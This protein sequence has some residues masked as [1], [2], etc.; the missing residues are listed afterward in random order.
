MPYIYP[1]TVETRSIQ[2][3]YISRDREQRL[4]LKLMPIV[5]KNVGKI[6]WS[7]KDTYGGLQNLRGLDGRPTRV[8]RV[9]WTTYE[10]EPGVFGEF[11]VVT[12]TELTNRAQN[13][14]VLTTPIDVGDLVLEQDELLVQRENDRI[15]SSIWTLLTTGTLQILLDG[16]NGTQYGVNDAYTFQQYTPLVGWSNAGSSTPLVDFQNIQQKGYA[17]GRSVNFGAG[18]VAYCNQVTLNRLLNNQN[19]ADLAGRRNDM[20]ATLNNLVA[21]NTYFSKQNL[22]SIEVYDQGYYT[23]PPL[24][25]GVFKKFI[26]D[27]I[28]VVIGQRPGGVPVG[29]YVMTRCGPNNWKPGSYRKVI[30]RANG[31][32]GEVRIPPTIEVQRGHNGGPT[33]YYPSAVLVMNVG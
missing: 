31:I 5:E 6:R 16:P 18:A 21:M 24:K 26:P 7:Q 13:F 32:N 2:Q 10:Y 28:L 23:A 12:E 33:I 30:D 14:D 1:T 11:G 3:E 22:A 15:E 4:G 29:N 20:G 9:G 8:A 25:G 27:G 17:A 19:A